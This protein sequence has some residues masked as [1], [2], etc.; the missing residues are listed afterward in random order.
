M[1]PFF[2]MILKFFLS[3]RTTIFLLIALLCL[4]LY[5]SIAMPLNEEFQLLHIV[6]LLRW[7]VDNTFGITWWLWCS[8]AVLS[9]LAVNT[10]FCSVESVMRKSES[11]Q[12]LLIISP[13]IIHIGFLFI[14]VAHL[15]SSL[16]NFKGTAVVSNGSVLNLPNGLTVSFPS[17]HAVVDPSGYITEW[18]ADIEYIR[19]GK[20][21]KDVIRPNEPSF[22]DGLG[23]YI[24]TVRMEPFPT[25]LIEVSREPGALW[26][27]S[28]GILFLAGTITLLVLK[29]RREE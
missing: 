3:L 8:L 2:K 29:I 15:F 21:F 17:I 4:F 22:L 6:P 28:G 5:G 13:Q 25:A 18:S 12:W 11:K 1:M 9:I 14:L 24:K 26:A 10:L 16:G 23:I 19:Q 7:M 27:L 20:L